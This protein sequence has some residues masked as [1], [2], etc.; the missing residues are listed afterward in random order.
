LP[1]PRFAAGFLFLAAAESDRQP[2]STQAE[3]QKGSDALERARAH[4]PDR[5]TLQQR[6]G[7]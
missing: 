3:K 2:S 4:E 7:T 5:H 1:D 6:S